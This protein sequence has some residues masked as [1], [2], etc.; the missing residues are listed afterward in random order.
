MDRLLHAEEVS[1]YCSKLRA[2]SNYLISGESGSPEIGKMMLNTK[3][4]GSVARRCI[5]TLPDNINVNHP[6]IGIAKGILKLRRIAAATCETSLKAALSDPVS[7]EQIAA[8]PDISLFE[9]RLLSGTRK[10]YHAPYVKS[11]NAWQHWS[12]SRIAMREMRKPHNYGF[13]AGFV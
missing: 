4:F 2:I 7:L 11:P 12:F 8:Q 3:K 5:A 6:K 13:F 9:F 1:N 10:I